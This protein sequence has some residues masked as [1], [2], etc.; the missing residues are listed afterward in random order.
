M[1][2]HHIFSFAV[3][4]LRHT[5]QYI[6]SNLPKVQIDRLFER[7]QSAEDK[8]AVNYSKFPDDHCQYRHDRQTLALDYCKFDVVFLLRHRKSASTVHMRSTVSEIKN[9]MSRKRY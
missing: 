5:L 7:W 9:E 8:V 6:R 1:L 2:G 4:I 3:D